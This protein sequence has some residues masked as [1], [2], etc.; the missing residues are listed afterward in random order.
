MCLVFGVCSCEDEAIDEWESWQERDI[1]G[2]GQVDLLLRQPVGCDGADCVYMVL[3]KGAGSSSEVFKVKALKC[4]IQGRFHQGYADIDCVRL[5]K[6]GVARHPEIRVTERFVKGPTRYIGQLDHLIHRGPSEGC[7][8][9]KATQ[10][11]SLFVLPARDIKVSQ[12]TKFGWR[13]GD[14]GTQLF[15]PLIK[16][17]SLD[18]SEMVVDPFGNTWLGV[19]ERG[20][21]EGWVPARAT[22]C[23]L[24]DGQAQTKRARSPFAQ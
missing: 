11:T 18:I 17:R 2:D 4:Q 10:T 20:A 3:E 6:T 23:G 8:Q 14:R 19:G 9:A 7:H 22:S 15:R 12:K 24:G 5:V 1:N 21:L 16:G 13:Q